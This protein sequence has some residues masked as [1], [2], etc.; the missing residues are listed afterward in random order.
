MLGPY[1]WEKK[2]IVGSN[3]KLLSIKLAE[4]IENKLQIK[5]NKKYLRVALGIRVITK[6][7]TKYVL[8]E[9]I[10]RP[11]CLKDVVP[12]STRVS[13]Q[14]EIERDIAAIIATSRLSS[15][16]SK[17]Y[18]SSCCCFQMTTPRSTLL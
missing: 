1:R 8:A 2:F 15:P 13:S 14:I 11:S 12:K 18:L 17:E 3:F 9:Y 7:A 16:L 6:Y 10:M 5:K 4:G